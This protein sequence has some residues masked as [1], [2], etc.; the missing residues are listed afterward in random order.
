MLML[1]STFLCSCRL[2]KDQNVDFTS[3]NMGVKTEGMW[4]Q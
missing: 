1:I 3:A 4:E 2:P